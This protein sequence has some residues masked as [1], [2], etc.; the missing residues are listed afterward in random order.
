MFETQGGHAESNPRPSEEGV[1][2]HHV[3]R[4][5]DCAS[6]PVSIGPVEN[7]KFWRASVSYAYKMR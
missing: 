7:V 3:L 2:F 5:L 1:S 6:L 4:P